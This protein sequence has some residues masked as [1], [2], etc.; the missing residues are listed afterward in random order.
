VQ[1]QNCVRL[2]PTCS[3]SDS[4]TNVVSMICNVNI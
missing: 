1:Q 4:E 2:S 3:C